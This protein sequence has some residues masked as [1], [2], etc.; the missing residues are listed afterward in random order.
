MLHCIY[1]LSKVDALVVESVLHVR[2]FTAESNLVSGSSVHL[3][4]CHTL[5]GNVSV[6][7]EGELDLLGLSGEQCAM[8]REDVKYLQNSIGIWRINTSTK[9]IPWYTYI[10]VTLTKVMQARSESSPQNTVSMA[11]GC[12][13]LWQLHTGNHCVHANTYRPVSSLPAQS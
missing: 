4:G 5:S 9:H 2:S 12:Y 6:A 10:Q 11:S 13:L 7:I 1:L 8:Q 3:A